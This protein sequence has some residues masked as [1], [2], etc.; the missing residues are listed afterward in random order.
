MN[1][2]N[3]FFNNM[4]LESIKQA[5]TLYTQLGIDPEAKLMA[6]GGRPVSIVYNGTAV[7]DLLA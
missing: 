6:S 7:K 2:R 5:A 3:Y 4:L 1:F